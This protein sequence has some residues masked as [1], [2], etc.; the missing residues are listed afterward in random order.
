MTVCEIQ[1]GRTAQTSGTAAKKGCIRSSSIVSLW[2]SATPPPPPKKS[3]EGRDPFGRGGGVRG[4]V[5]DNTN[6]AVQNQNHDQKKT[7]DRGGT[8]PNQLSHLGG[9]RNGGHL[10][11][12][13]KEGR[14]KATLRRPLLNGDFRR[15]GGSINEVSSE[16]QHVTISLF[17]LHFLRFRKLRSGHVPLALEKGGANRGGKEEWEGGSDDGQICKGRGWGRR[18]GSSGP[19]HSKG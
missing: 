18:T 10:P 9:Y 8:Q 17:N 1:R 13:T 2:P 5:S 15:P 11:V 6:W 14:K 3:T 7:P 4:G 19:K 12:Q 16:W